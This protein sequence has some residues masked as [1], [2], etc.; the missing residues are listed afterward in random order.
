MNQSRPVSYILW[1]TLAVLTLLGVVLATQKKPPERVEE[2]KEKA[3]PVGV[4]TL[5]AEPI[6][7]VLK[8]P[9]RIEP[10]VDVKVATE[11]GGRIVEVAID[12]GARV[13]AGQV[14]L[15][16]D[17]RVWDAHL[18]QMEIEAREAQ[19]E[20]DRWQELQKTGGMSASDF[21]RVQ[22]ARDLTAVG[23][24]QATINLSQ[25]R[26]VSPVAG[27]VD[28]RYVE[29][30]EYAVEGGA[31]FRIVD[32]SAV[33]VVA[34]VP[35]RDVLSVKPSM[36][37]P[38]RV[39]ALP[40]RAFTGTVTFVSLVGS[41]ESNSFRTEIR[42]ANGEHLLKP[43][44]IAEVALSRGVNEKGVSVPMSAVIPRRGEYV[45][46]VAENGRAASRFVKLGRMLGQNVVVE[47]G[48]KAG[49]AVVVEG[50]RGLQD[51]SLLEVKARSE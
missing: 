36:A 3:I 22:K 2:N 15:K 41:R 5:Q 38:F 42:A 13:E 50:Q 47:S 25:C 29:A 16:L 30:G 45:V 1:S 18:K 40:D 19:K 7:D 34:E 51:G 21:D 11:K 26:V 33:K 44:M 14:L 37:M 43:G 4:V 27:V 24:E 20:F 35:E 48:L 32:D 8:I 6:V 17:S 39:S 49:D 10:L 9:A 23:L 12:R 31:A 28:D 46:Y